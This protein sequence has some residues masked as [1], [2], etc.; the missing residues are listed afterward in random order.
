[1]SP[2][3]VRPRPASADQLFG[4]ERERSPSDGGA[5][6]QRAQRNRLPSVRPRSALRASADPLAVE[7]ECPRHCHRFLNIVDDNSCDAMIHDLWHCTSSERN[8][9]RSIGHRFDHHQSEWFRPIDRKQQRH[10]PTQ[11]DF[12]LLITNFANE[13]NPRTLQQ[14]IGFWSCSKPDQLC[15]PLPRF[16]KATR[17]GGQSRPLSPHLSRG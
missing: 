8:H 15:R 1:M 7:R 10:C 11:E 3:P 14:P 2:T 17:R 16:F 12:L 5:S 6:G 9:R 13:F 4:R